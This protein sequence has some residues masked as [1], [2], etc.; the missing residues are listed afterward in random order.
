[1]K[2][3]IYCVGMIGRPLTPQL[4]H[5]L[6]MEAQRLIVKKQRRVDLRSED[7]YALMTTEFKYGNIADIGGILFS[8][9]LYFE[10]GSTK[11]NFVVKPLP[12]GL[13]TSHEFTYTVETV[14]AP[15][16]PIDLN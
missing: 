8:I 5:Y 15:T 16:P 14:N 1:M 13:M 10:E 3:Q 4:S 12:P 9:E 11:G 2:E 7:Y 6:F